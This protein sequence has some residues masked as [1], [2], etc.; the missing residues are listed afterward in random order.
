VSCLILSDHLK[1]RRGRGERGEGYE[2][3]GERESAKWRRRGYQKGLGER[4][5]CGKGERKKERD[6]KDRKLETD[7]KKE[8]T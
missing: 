8:D 4:R 3:D 6:K 2:M 5:E 1:G 7:I